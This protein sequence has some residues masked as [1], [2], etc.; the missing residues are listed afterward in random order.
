MCLFNLCHISKLVFFLQVLLLYN[1]LSPTLF[2][3]TWTF[4]IL[5]NLMAYTSSACNPLL[6]SAFSHKFR[7]KFQQLLKPC[8]CC[9]NCF[10]AP[11]STTVYNKSFCLGG[12]RSSRAKSVKTTVTEIWK[13]YNLKTKIT[14]NKTWWPF[15]LLKS[16]KYGAFLYKV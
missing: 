8:S 5:V 12:C 6:Y 2:R 16:S 9:C 13:Y 11:S 14:C 15:T 7:R 4:L 1:T 3:E 10:P